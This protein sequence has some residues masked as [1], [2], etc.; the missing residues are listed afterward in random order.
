MPQ[1]TTFRLY[2]LSIGLLFAGYVALEYHRPKPL[3]WTATYINKD[4]IPYGTYVLYDQLPQLLGTDSIEAVRLPVYNQLTGQSLREGPE[5]DHPTVEDDRTTPGNPDTTANTDPTDSTSDSAAAA[6]STATDEA[7]KPG[8]SAETPPTTTLAPAP[9]NHGEETPDEEADAEESA[10]DRPLRLRPEQANYLFINQEFELSR[11]DVRALLRFVARGNDAFVAAQRFGR[12][13]GLLRD[14]VGFDVE[15]VDLTTHPNA[16][17]IPVVDSVEVRFTNPGLARVRYRLPG[18]SVAQ[19]LVV[20]S[21]RVGRTLATDAQG[22]AVFVRL[23]YGRGHFYLCTAP[24]AFTN[25]YLLR[26]RT[27]AF[28]ASALA[29]LPARRTWWDEYQKQGPVGEQSLLRVVLAHEALRLAYYLSLAGTLLFVLVEA[30]RRQ[31]VIPTIKPL[32]NTTL[33]FTRTVASLYRQGSSHAL[34][35]EKKVGLFLDYLRTRFQETNPDL[36]DDA[37]RERLSQK[38]GLARSRVDELLRLVNFAR[39]APQLTDRDLLLLSKALSDF[40]RE[41]GR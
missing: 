35:A 19:R 2:L 39:T 26:P 1:F 10:D 16:K 40:K 34:I 14:S 13:R 17:G 9:T 30:R 41:A 20:D 8:D 12:T 6:A 7:T 23:A 24:V 11:P 29:Y 37:F 31:R 3:D 32:P 21:G 22:R 28:A 5:A 27:T 15:D 25:Y 38:A 4:K 36:G 33:L 18:T